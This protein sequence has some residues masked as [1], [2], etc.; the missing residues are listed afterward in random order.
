MNDCSIG[1][2]ARLISCVLGALLYRHVMCRHAGC[3]IELAGLRDSDQHRS[4]VLYYCRSMMKYAD[5]YTLALMPS[6]HLL[7]DAR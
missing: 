1:Q 5:V 6:K 4:T 3:V 7:P 2:P